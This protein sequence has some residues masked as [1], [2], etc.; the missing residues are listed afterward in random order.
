MDGGPSICCGCSH[1][2]FLTPG[3]PP[4]EIEY[5]VCNVDICAFFCSLQGW[6][7]RQ[8]DQATAN[9][10]KDKL[11]LIKVL[12]LS[13]THVHVTDIHIHIYTY[14]SVAILAQRVGILLGEHHSAPHQSLWPYVYVVTC[15]HFLPRLLDRFKNILFLFVHVL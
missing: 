11:S 5:K 6:V 3:S 15:L 9:I 2:L 10:G 7:I 14:G 8:S 1:N 4:N 12:A 13:Q